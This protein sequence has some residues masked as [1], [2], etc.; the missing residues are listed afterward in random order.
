[1]GVELDLVLKRKFVPHD[2][3]YKCPNLKFLLMSRS[4]CFK[5]P[6]TDI[7]FS[8]RTRKFSSSF[9]LTINTFV[10]SISSSMLKYVVCK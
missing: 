3:F 4:I 5:G 1:M 7:Q 6:N 8:S 10:N 9:C 2:L